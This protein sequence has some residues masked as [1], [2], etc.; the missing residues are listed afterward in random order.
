[1]ISMRLERITRNNEHNNN[2]GMNKMTELTTREKHLLAILDSIIQMSDKCESLGGLVS[3]SGVASAATMQ[4]SIQ[5]NKSRIY[6]LVRPEQNTKTKTLKKK[7]S[8]IS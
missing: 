2:Q 4:T 6:A 1:M 3:I 7:P 5:K 8:Q